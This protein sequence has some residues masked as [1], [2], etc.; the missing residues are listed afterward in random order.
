MD[1]GYLYGPLIAYHTPQTT[2]HLRSTLHS[3]DEASSRHHQP[4]Y[5]QM[6]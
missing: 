3:V 6:E 1:L 2:I 5:Y 4:T